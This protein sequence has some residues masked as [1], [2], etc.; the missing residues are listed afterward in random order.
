MGGG[1]FLRGAHLT[2]HTSFT[3]TEHIS[4][5]EGGRY[6]SELLISGIKHEDKVSISHLL[7]RRTF[8]LKSVKL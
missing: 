7:A 4:G 2:A 3:L 8:R 5:R 6:D 1:Q